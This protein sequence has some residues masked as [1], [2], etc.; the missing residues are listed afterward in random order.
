[1]SEISVID[2]YVSWPSFILISDYNI[3]SKPNDNLNK[4][5]VN[6]KVIAHK[7]GPTQPFKKI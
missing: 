1:M 5:F 7:L 6:H 2:K 4:P 3:F